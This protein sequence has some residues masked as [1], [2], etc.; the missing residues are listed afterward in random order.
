MNNDLISREALKAEV[1]WFKHTGYDENNKPLFEYV[2]L[3]TLLTI[4]DRAPAVEEVSEIEFKEPLPMVKAQ[5]IVKALSKEPQ[6]EWVVAYRSCGDTYYVCSACKEGKAMDLASEDL[7]I[8]DFK[9]CP[10]CGAFMKRGS[11]E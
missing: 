10:N 3:P 7:T 1:E 11:M 9:R 6:G 2:E 8:K 5:K 4:I